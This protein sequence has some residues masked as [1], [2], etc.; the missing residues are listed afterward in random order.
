[1]NQAA[2]AAES[3]HQ[4]VSQNWPWRAERRCWRPGPTLTARH[5][6]MMQKDMTCWVSEDHGVLL[7]ENHDKTSVPFVLCSI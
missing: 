2:A 5:Q 1:V 6:C 3:P 7:V 4:L